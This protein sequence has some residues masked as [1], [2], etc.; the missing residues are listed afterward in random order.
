M[1]KKDSF[2]IIL[3]SFITLLLGCQ[4]TPVTIPEFQVASTERVVLVEYLTGVKCP[5]C[6]KGSTILKGVKDKFPKNM[7]IVGIHGRFLTEPLSTSKFDFR[8]EFSRQLEESYRPFIGKPASMINRVKFPDEP[9]LAADFPDL[10]P[11]YI[12]DEISNKP[13]IS[14][15]SDHTLNR[16]TRKIDLNIGVQASEILSGAYKVSVYVT[17]SGIIDPQESVGTV[18][19]DY[20]HDHVLRHM[21]TAWDGDVLGQNLQKGDLI[22]KT[23]SYTVPTIYNLDNLTIVIAVSAQSNREVLQAHKIEL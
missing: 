16:S 21:M 23:F 20:V 5:N 8:N 13:K 14:I 1:I 22:N 19:K 15:V 7:I 3:L 18:I 10:W 11:A 4:E 9:N 2:H 6:P 17:E 12:T